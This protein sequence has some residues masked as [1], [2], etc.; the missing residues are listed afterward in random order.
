MAEENYSEDID[1]YNQ[2][3]GNLHIIFLI[4]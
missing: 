4:S 3:A 2:L 1:P